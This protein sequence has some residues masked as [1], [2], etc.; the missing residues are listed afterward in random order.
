MSN[1]NIIVT[2]DHPDAVSNTIRYAR[3]DN[4]V[5]PVY[6][7]VTGVVTSPYVIADVPQGQYR[8]YIKPVY[9]DGRVCG[10]TV[11]DTEACTGIQALSAVV[12]GSNFV[13]SYTANIAVPFVQVNI[14]YPNGGSST[15]QYTNDGSDIV[16]PVPSGV[17]GTF[18]ITMSPVCDQETGWIGAASAPVSVTVS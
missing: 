15:H 14:A 16:I 3:I 8:V 2:F 12:S 11:Q 1:F 9:A 7:T 10:E 6:T 4:T 18:F 17:T 13:I 5:S